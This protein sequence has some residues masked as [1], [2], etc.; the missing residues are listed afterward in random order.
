MADNKNKT[1]KNKIE[2]NDPN[3]SKLKSK[4]TDL[5]NGGMHQI[6]VY[7]PSVIIDSHMH[8]QSGNCAPA[9]IL[10]DRI[11]VLGA[12]NPS[13]GFIEGSGRVIYGTVD[14]LMQ[15]HIIAGVNRLRK[16]KN[17]DGE[18]YRRHG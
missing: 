10:W 11:P 14:L 4:K 18:Y 1:V 8:I 9:H 15:K 13:R 5:L 12:A 2:Q 17:E 7:R 16:K 3:G 6:S